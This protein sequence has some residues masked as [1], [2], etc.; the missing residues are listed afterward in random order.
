MSDKEMGSKDGTRGGSGTRGRDSAT[1]RDRA[2]DA[3]RRKSAA[4]Q[5]KLMD[6]VQSRRRRGRGHAKRRREAWRANRAE[7][8]ASVT[9]S[10]ND[11]RG[12][13]VRLLRLHRAR[14]VGRWLAVSA[15]AAWSVVHLEQAT[16]RPA[17]GKERKV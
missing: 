7:Q 8:E 17:Q 16:R 5:G 12:A 2:R 10:V 14:L 15:R 11:G 4:Q 3:G 6:K 1:A 13:A 9:E